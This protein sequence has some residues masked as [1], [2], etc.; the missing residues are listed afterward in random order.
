MI[1]VFGAVPRVVR[2]G[3]YRRRVLEPAALVAEVMGE[4]DPPDPLE[5][6]DLH[7]PFEPPAP[8]EL[9]GP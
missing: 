2:L 3:W 7:D 6:P 1:A 8:P 9:P 5:P 4:V